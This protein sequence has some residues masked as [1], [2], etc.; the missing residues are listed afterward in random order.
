[1]GYRSTLKHGG[2]SGRLPKTVNILKPVTTKIYPY[3]EKEQNALREK[4][5]SK[6]PHGYDK[7]IK[8]PESYPSFEE[9]TKP[10]E[11]V[12]LND[13]IDEKLPKVVP[14]TITTNSDNVFVNDIR[15]KELELR[16]KYYREI[17]LKEEKQRVLEYET[18][19]K[20]K[21]QKVQNELVS[22]NKFKGSLRN[23]N[24]I[25]LPTIE[26]IKKFITTED[27]KAYPMVRALNAKELEFAE[28]KEE[29]E[30]L[31]EKKAKE[32]AKMNTL[33]TLIGQIDS[34]ILNEVH[35][36]QKLEEI[37]ES[38]EETMYVDEDGNMKHADIMKHFHAIK[39]D[40]I[41]E[42]LDDTLFDFDKKENAIKFEHLAKYLKENRS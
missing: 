15:Q 14:D 34:Y 7:S 30:F 22:I 5:N 4:I 3:I 39:E 16:K 29:V 38:E 40:K 9:L 8:L 32:I 37:F 17:L 24:A 42:E 36:S 11:P 19:Q 27:G 33:Q 21:E 26:N 6:Y 20:I 35:L 23:K 18:V 13:Y 12:N 2:V 28:A 10:I 1:M 25:V 31:Q 41:L